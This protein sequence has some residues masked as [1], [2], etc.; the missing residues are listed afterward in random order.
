[1][2]VVSGMMAVI[3]D[4]PVIGM[5]TANAARLGMVYSRP[6]TAVTGPTV[7]GRR[8]ARTASAKAMMKP[9]IIGIDQQLQVLP[10]LL[11]DIVEVAG[12]PVP[13]DLDHE[14]GP[15]PAAA[16]ALPR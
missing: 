13:A 6:V 9:A 3:S 7:P 5:S 14:T 11:R 2:Y 4:R 1:M 15:T 12:D 16:Q 8:K 10:G